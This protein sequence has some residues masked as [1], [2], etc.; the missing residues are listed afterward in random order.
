VLR[1]A[2][3]QDPDIV[4][5]GEMRDQETAQIG[6]RA[7]MT[8][9]L[10]LSTLHT[11]D[12]VSTALRL[13]DMGAE[14]YVVATSLRAV[15]A[16]RLVRRICPSC[17]APVQLS[18]QEESWLR[19]RLG[20]NVDTQVFKQGSGCTQCNNTGYQG[21]IGIFE[22]LEMNPELTDALRRNNSSDFAKAASA[23]EGFISL[24]DC[25]LAYARRGITSIEEV[26]RVAGQV[27]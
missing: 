21:R 9:H 23:Q 25:A 13:I 16:Q 19:T 7:A 4:M 26:I 20:E 8:G 1:T 14:G 18:P 3:R 10:V 15:L 11:N 2:L 12:S 27:D 6:L 17:A 24:T 5:V 22:L